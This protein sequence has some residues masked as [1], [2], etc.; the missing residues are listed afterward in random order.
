MNNRQRISRRG[1]LQLAATATLGAWSC[2]GWGSTDG[3]LPPGYPIIDT[4][5]HLWD[6]TKLQPPWLKTADPILAR[7]YVTEDYLR[8][9]R[10]FQLEKAIY[11][12]VDVAPSQFAEEAELIVPICADPNHPTA[13]AIISGDPN[14]DRFQDYLNRVLNKRY[15]KGLRRVL[16]VPSRPRGFCLQPQ[17]IRS[18]KLLG[19]LDL[20]FDLCMRPGELS[21][22]AK[23]AS[24]APQTRFIVDHCGNADP[25]AFV[26][27]GSAGFRRREQRAPQHSAAQW[28]R[29]MGAL[30]ARENVFCKISGVVVR[31]AE[32]WDADDL[33]PIVNFCLDEFGPDRVVF[34]GDWPVCRLRAKLGDWIGALQQIIRSRPSAD[35]RK[36][37]SD[38]ARTIYRV[39]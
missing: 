11:M 38:N 13:A 4:H 39:A 28:K 33:A 7:S 32:R 6:L 9:M 16:H 12:E 24:L 2:E 34:G 5:Q 10:G 15:V 25:L 14:S 27:P 26:T 31:A 23:L 22:G 29:D 37:W 30:A 21:D 19:D 36:L 3:Q 18:M 17:F 1:A 20:S 8:E 35:Q